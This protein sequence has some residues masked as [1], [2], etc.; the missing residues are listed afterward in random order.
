MKVEKWLSYVIVGLM[1]LLIVFN[2]IGVFWM[3]VLDK[4]KDIVILKFMGM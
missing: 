3:I 2:L 4:C 1:M